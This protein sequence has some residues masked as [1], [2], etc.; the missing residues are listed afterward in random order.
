[1]IWGVFI[2]WVKALAMRYLLKLLLIYKGWMYESRS[3][4]G[5]SIWTRLWLPCVALLTI[6]K[7]Q[8]YSYQ[9]SL[10]RLPLPS[11]NE[12]VERYL[13]S[14]RPIC[15]TDDDY[16]RIVKLAE[17]F[18]SGISS[19]LQRYLILKSWWATNFVSSRP[20]SSDASPMTFS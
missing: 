5:I 19:R 13:R 17:E 2:W 6:K 20:L 1:L 12:T 16:N 7:P 10:P 4:S 8:L 11:V 15:K 9:A 3:G 14:I 18:E